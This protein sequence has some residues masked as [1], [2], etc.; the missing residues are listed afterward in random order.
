MLPHVP[1][2]LGF[3][4]QGPLTLYAFA[5]DAEGNRARCLGRTDPADHDA[6]VDHDGERHDCEA[7]RG[8]RHAGAGPDGERALANFGWVLTP[9]SNTVADG[10][11]ILMPTN[12]STMRVF[13]DGV[14][15]GTVTYNQCR[16]T[17]G[18][19]VPAGRVL[20]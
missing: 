17:V 9:D 16:G 1:N 5:T 15:V 19:P 12:G 8:D 3:G 14:S 6:D 2:S 4:G 7:V 11:D 20:Q 18:N 13:I 10:T